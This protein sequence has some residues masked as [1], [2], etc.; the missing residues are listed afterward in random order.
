IIS[1][2]HFNTYCETNH[3]KC[4]TTFVNQEN[5]WNFADARIFLIK[6]EGKYRIYQDE[7][8]KNIITT[9]GSLDTL[10]KELAEEIISNH[11]KKRCIASLKELIET[12]VI[13]LKK[14]INVI[15][16]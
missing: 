14:I 7:A 8:S 1:S 2:I 9:I 12:I 16:T 4:L 5:I 3:R 15:C 6:E 10:D 13:E 11:N